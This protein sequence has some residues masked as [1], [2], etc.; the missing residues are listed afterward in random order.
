MTAP[1]VP[2]HLFGH[3][4]EESS[5][6]IHLGRP[7]EIPLG[8]TCLGLCDTDFPDHRAKSCDAMM[9]MTQWDLPRMG[10]FIR[11]L[12]T[13]WPWHSQGHSVSLKEI[14][15]V[16]QLTPFAWDR[17]HQICKSSIA[18]DS[19]ADSL[20]CERLMFA[21]RGIHL[22]LPVPSFLNCSQSPRLAHQNWNQINKPNCGTTDC[23]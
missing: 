15:C 23:V 22:N 16:S 12:G 2:L 8:S 7:V 9:M 6:V 3:D 10:D 21:L 19:I 1:P 17:P 18:F 11:S 14:P 13:G 20:G 4:V 5:H